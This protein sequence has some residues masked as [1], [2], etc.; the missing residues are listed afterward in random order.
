M[1][2]QGL[3]AIQTMQTADSDQRICVSQIAMCVDKAQAELDSHADTTV[4]SD[5]TALIIQDF[6][7][8]VCVH[9]CDESVAQ[10]DSC[11]T[12]TGILAY[13]HLATGITHYLIF[14]QAIL[15][16]CMKYSL[17]SIMQL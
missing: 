9:G 5:D 11:P 17:I 8:P 7:C 13:D 3:A 1:G 15:I 16:P 10:Q 12:V 4:L 6:N 2:N 14:H